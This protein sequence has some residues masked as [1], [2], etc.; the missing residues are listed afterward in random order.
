MLLAQFLFQVADLVEH[1][2]RQPEHAGK[3]VHQSF[4]G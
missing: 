2:G 4:L 1:I 3:F